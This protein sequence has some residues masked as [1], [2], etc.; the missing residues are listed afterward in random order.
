MM[1]CNTVGKVGQEGPPMT[2]IRLHCQILRANLTIGN[3]GC[4]FGVWH[5]S[6]AVSSANP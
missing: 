2:Y 3:S 6:S 5:N 4:N 1:E